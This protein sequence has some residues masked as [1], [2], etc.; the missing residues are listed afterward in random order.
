MLNPLLGS[1]R[2]ISRERILSKATIPVLPELSFL[3]SR[4]CTLLELGVCVCVGGGRWKLRETLYCDGHELVTVGTV[5]S[6]DR[7]CNFSD[8]ASGRAR[9]I[10][11]LLVKLCSVCRTTQPTFGQQEH[12]EGSL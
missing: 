8:L 3:G 2:L 6:Q 12:T 11:I 5:Q 9:D 1:D 10:L 7:E 4:L